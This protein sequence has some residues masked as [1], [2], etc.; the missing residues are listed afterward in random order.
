MSKLFCG[1]FLALAA[2]SGGAILV[3][4]KMPEPGGATT[5]GDLTTFSTGVVVDAADGTDPCERLQVRLYTSATAPAS[6]TSPP[7][8]API[9]SGSSLSHYRENHHCQIVILGLPARADYWV[10]VTYPAKSPAGDPY[11]ATAKPS[12]VTVPPGVI[13]F[14]PIAVVDNQSAK[15][16]GTMNV[17]IPSIPGP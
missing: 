6:V 3:D 15:R 10:I 14:Y 7:S 8:S 16:N 17:E 5:S 11:Y 13:G 9:A 4:L 1:S 12:L 2:C